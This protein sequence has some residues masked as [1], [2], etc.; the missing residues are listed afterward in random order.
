MI[1]DVALLEMPSTSVKRKVTVPEGRWLRT[2]VI[3]RQLKGYVT[4]D[5]RNE[6]PNLTYLRKCEITLSSACSEKEWKWQAWR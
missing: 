4:G 6:P 1:V 2:A 3:M 5:E